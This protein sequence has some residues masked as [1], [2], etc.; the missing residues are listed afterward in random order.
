MATEERQELLRSAVTA[1]KS[2][3]AHYA[4]LF[5]DDIS[6]HP[7]LYFGDPLTAEFATLGVNP[8]ATE[9]TRSRWPKTELTI[10]ELDH[11]STSYFRNSARESHEWFDRYELSL[12]ILGHSY[13]S[14]KANRSDTVHIDLSPRATRAMG[15]VSKTPSL[16]TRFLEM[17]AS[18]MRFFLSAL[19]LC[20][21]VRAAV[22][23]G[24]VT[25]AHYFDEFVCKYLP[26]GYS[27]KLETEFARGRGATTLYKLCGP[28]F[29]IPVLFCG[30]SPSSRNKGERLA[31]E[32]RSNLACLKVAGF[33]SA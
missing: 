26:T 5:K 23:S 1:V 19:G 31:S 32:I 21:N 4:P 28:T 27:L 6:T 11:S 3:N 18:D 29:A 17:V 22:M 10:P 24:S 12:N 16:R 8:S 30:S 33:C 25:N 13:S 14:K 20:S 15:T 7:I 9:F 2:T